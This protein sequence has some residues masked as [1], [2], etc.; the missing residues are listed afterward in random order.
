VATAMSAT[1]S[2][3]ARRHSWLMVAGMRPNIGHSARVLRSRRRTWRNLAESGFW[4]G[5]SDCG[6]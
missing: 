1:G 2:G 4:A 3:A 6:D 5:I